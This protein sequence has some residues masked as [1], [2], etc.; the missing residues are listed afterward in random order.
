MYTN[1]YKL[2]NDTL[3]QIGSQ[4][5]L[6]HQDFYIIN[7]DYYLQ[8]NDWNIGFAIDKLTMTNELQQNGTVEMK[9][10]VKSK[11]FLTTNVG[12]NYGGLFLFIVNETNNVV[13]SKYLAYQNAKHI[14]TFNY[15]NVLYATYF[16]IEI[17]NDLINENL[18]YYINTKLDFDGK[19][20]HDDNNE[21]LTYN[22]VSSNLQSLQTNVIYSQFIDID[23]KINERKFLE[24][25]PK[26]LMPDKTIKQ[27]ILEMLGIEDYLPTISLKYII[28]FMNSEGTVQRY[29]VSNVDSIYNTIGFM[30]DTFN[31]VGYDLSKLPIIIQVTM[32]IDVDGFKISRTK[33]LTYQYFI[34]NPNS[35]TNTISFIPFLRVITAKEFDVVNQNIIEIPDDNDPVV[36]VIPIDNNIFIEKLNENAKLDDFKGYI[37]FENTENYTNLI[38]SIDKFAIKSE[39]NSNVFDLRH[40]FDKLK[41]GMKY[42]IVDLNNNK[43]ILTGEIIE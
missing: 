40:I 36:E 32:I 33:S 42:A 10:V 2:N 23:V 14:N 12:L 6:D 15:N 3:L 43:T 27:Y 25:T 17:P 8:H 39:P 31:L 41:I 29:E 21:V 34:E 13:Y 5:D 26:S 4:D 37:N 7:N 9:D 28:S 22:T 20:M 38:F 18:R 24:I 11:L 16:D 30:I 19:Y 1:K 35:L